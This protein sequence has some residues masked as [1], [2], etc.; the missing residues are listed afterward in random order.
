[1]ATRKQNNPTTAAKELQEAYWKAIA[2]IREQELKEGQAAWSHLKE[3]DLPLLEEHIREQSRLNDELRAQLTNAQAYY[4]EED[5]IDPLVATPEERQDL[6]LP[7]R[8]K[9]GKEYSFYEAILRK[10]KDKSV[11][12]SGLFWYY[13]GDGWKI[14]KSVSVLAYRVFKKPEFIE[15]EE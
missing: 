9:A 3:I 8:V 6:R 4:A 1:M 12:V 14:P 15:A 11:F 10:I 2:E 7:S 13:G 5:W